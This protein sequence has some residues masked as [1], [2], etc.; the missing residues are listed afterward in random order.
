[1]LTH[2]NCRRYAD[3]C[4]QMSKVAQIPENRARLIEMAAAWRRLAD[5]AD[6]AA[7][8]REERRH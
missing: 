7:K 2:E 6:D 8:D 4:Q 1:M 5:M 3:E